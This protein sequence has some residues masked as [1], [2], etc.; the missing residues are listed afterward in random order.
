MFA[1]F[2]RVSLALMLFAST[3]LGADVDGNY[4][5]WGAGGVVCKAYADMAKAQN[6]DFDRVSFWVAGYLTAYNRLT[7]KT[8][9]IVEKN[10]NIST[11]M[12]WL[13]S[14]CNKNPDEI[15]NLA[16]KAYTTEHE[17]DRQET[18]PPKK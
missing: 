1:M 4:S 13:L 2:C 5:Y 18:A 11:A 12:L 7:D 17:K 16:M 3:A 14:H 9:D 6:A 15:L 8:F 10:G